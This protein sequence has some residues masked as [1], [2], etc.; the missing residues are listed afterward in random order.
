MSPSQNPSCIICPFCYDSNDSCQFCQ[1]QLSAPSCSRV[2]INIS[3]YLNSYK[4]RVLKKEYLDSNTA[5]GVLLRTEAQL[6]KTR[7]TGKKRVTGINFV[8]GFI[9]HRFWRKS[10]ENMIA[11]F[12]SIDRVLTKNYPLNP[13][14]TG[15]LTSNSHILSNFIFQFTRK[16][17]Q[18]K[19]P[20]FRYPFFS[21]R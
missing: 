2:F 13:N 10:N 14:F 6:Q 1:K 9:L 17:E 5:K 4:N 15:I 19:N 18:N 20:F 12:D 21:L 16:Q 7:A 11:K 3:E 8:C